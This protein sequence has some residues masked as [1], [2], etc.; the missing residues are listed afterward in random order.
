MAEHPVSHAPVDPATAGGAD[1]EVRAVLERRVQ[2]LW[3]K[4]SRGLVEL[5]DPGIVKFDLAPP[6]LEAGA[7]VRDTAGWE[8]WF[9]TWESPIGVEITQPAVRVE[10]SLALV[11]SLNRMRGTKVGGQEV[12]LWFRATVGLREVDGAWL[13]VHEHN[14]VPFL[15]DG[16]GLA[17]LELRP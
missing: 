14:S 17:A 10:G 9:A 8:A 15:M 4:D 2:C 16:S 1:E 6:L 12:D 5:Y 11:H 7:A 13:I 3:E